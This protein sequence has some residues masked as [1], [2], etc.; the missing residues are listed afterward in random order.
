MTSNQGMSSR[1]IASAVIAVVLTIGVHGGWLRG[2][3]HDA[4][5]V[6]APAAA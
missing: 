3:D 5:A 1:R 6:T 2:L 4:A